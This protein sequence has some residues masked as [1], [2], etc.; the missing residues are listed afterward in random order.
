MI[1]IF[2]NLLDNTTAKELLQWH[3]SAGWVWGHN[4]TASNMVEKI[5][6]FSVIHAG[7]KNHDQTYYDCEKELSESLLLVWKLIKEKLDNDDVLV[8]CYANLITVGIDQRLHYD[9]KENDSKTVIIYL[10]ETWNVDWAGETIFWDREKREIVKSILPKFNTAVIF[11][12]NIWHGVRPV[13]I[14]CKEPRITLMFK[15]KKLQGENN[16]IQP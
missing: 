16:V 8:R 4:S 13:S 2:E 9:D 7:V 12:G 5:P 6:H 3:L 15:T 1:T 10:N 14:F 11:P